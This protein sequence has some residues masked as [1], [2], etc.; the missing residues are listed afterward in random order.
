VL[1][2][3]PWVAE[4]IKNSSVTCAQ[5]VWLPASWGPVSQHPVLVNP[6]I[7]SRLHTCNVVPNTFF[8]IALLFFKIKSGYDK[9]I[10]EYQES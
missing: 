10:F 4:K 2:S 6:V 3:L 9:R 7:G 8:A 5:T 1:K